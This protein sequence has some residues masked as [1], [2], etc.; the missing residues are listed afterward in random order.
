MSRSTNRTVASDRP[1]H[2]L[3]VIGG[4]RPNPRCLELIAPAATVVC[5]DSGVD[6]ARALG[7]V[8]H[9]VVGDMDSISETARS[10]ADEVGARSMIAPRDKDLTDT[11]LALD[12]IAALGPRA[13]T[14]LWGGGD[15]IDHVVGVLAALADPIL[16]D[17]GSLE[18]WVAND[19]VRVVHGP[20]SIDVEAATDSTLSL[21]PLAGSVTGVSTS[22]LRWDLN[23]E[24]LHAHRARGVSN[25]VTG[26][27]RIS[28]ESGVLGV[29]HPGHVAHDAPKRNATQDDRDTREQS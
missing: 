22:G 17:I 6:H 8:P 4:D 11:E 21:V 16:S 23:D 1:D 14:V 26:V 27:V 28:I 18:L 5:A 9:L 2:V 20:R 10:W 29:V 19:L 15:R 12:A 25:E 13:L 3:L 24:T 7:L